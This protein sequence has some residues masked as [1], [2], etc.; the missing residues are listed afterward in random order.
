MLQTGDP[1]G[2]NLDHD[3]SK[4]A[5]D[6]PQE[7]GPAANLCGAETLR[8]SSRPKR[9]SIGHTIWQW[10]TQVRLVPQSGDA[11]LNLP[12]DLGPTAVS[13]SLPQ[14]HVRG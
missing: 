3:E 11:L 9:V 7:T 1:L 8:M 5:D 10:L 2:T 13:F 4:I 14:S 12:Q 6:K